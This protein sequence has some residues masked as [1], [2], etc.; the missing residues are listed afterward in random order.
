MNAYLGVKARSEK[1]V[2]LNVWVN[3]IIA[4]GKKTFERY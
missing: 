2:L 1:N 4:P 3:I